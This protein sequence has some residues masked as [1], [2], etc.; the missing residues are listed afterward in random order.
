MIGVGEMGGVTD[1]VGGEIGGG[2]EDGLGP[3]GVF[4]EKYGGAGGVEGGPH[5]GVMAEAEDE[6]V[7]GR[8]GSK[9]VEGETDLGE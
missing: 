8:D 2:L 6:E 7:A 9:D 1:G 3:F 4:F 5:D